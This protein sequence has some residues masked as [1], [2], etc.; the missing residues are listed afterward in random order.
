MFLNPFGYDWVVYGVNCLTHDYWMTMCVMY[1]LAGTF[2]AL[3]MFFYRINPLKAFAYHAK[4][5]HTHLVTKLGR[6]G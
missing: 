6:N 2:F 4:R 1:A 3:F 5:T